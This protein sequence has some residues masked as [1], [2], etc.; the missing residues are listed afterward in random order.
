MQKF[1]QHLLMSFRSQIPIV[2][3]EE[4]ALQCLPDSFLRLMKLI[5]SSI[6]RSTKYEKKSCRVQIQLIVTNTNREEIHD[7]LLCDALMHLIFGYR[8]YEHFPN[9]LLVS[10]YL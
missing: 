5:S 4:D 2:L 8:M 7:E 1:H 6:I 10:F 3:N 9:K